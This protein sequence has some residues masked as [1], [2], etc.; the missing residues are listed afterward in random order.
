ML[1]Y[2]LKIDSCHIDERYISRVPKL[3]ESTRRKQAIF[4][5]GL[6]FYS[7]CGNFRIRHWLLLQC[8]VYF[9]A[10]FCPVRLKLK[11]ELFKKM[12][13][14]LNYNAHGVT[15]IIFLNN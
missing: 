5:K 15:K 4:N 11:I 2:H 9:W 6:L 13:D 14:I 10:D 12:I 3:P 1:W 7:H 8:T